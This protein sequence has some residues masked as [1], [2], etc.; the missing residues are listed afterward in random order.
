MMPSGNPTR[1]LDGGVN[2]PINALA[3]KVACARPLRFL[4]P[5]RRQHDSLKLRTA[6]LRSV[7]AP[8]ISPDPCRPPSPICATRVFSTLRFCA[9][10]TPCIFGLEATFLDG[11]AI[12]LIQIRAL[13]HKKADENWRFRQFLKG[14]CDLKPDQIDRHVFET[15]RRVWA[16][17]NCTACANCC[18]EVKPSFSAGTHTDV[19]YCV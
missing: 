6:E 1:K 12:D 9:V 13:S 3:A 19:S 11:M 5:L 8:P 14:Q 4:L 17:I 18:R 16:G 15:T 7:P 10:S 2:L